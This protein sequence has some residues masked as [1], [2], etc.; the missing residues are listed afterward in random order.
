MSYPQNKTHN[1]RL[2]H[3]VIHIIHRA[4][5]T[6]QSF[7]DKPYRQF[8]PS[9]FFLQ[10]A[11]HG[12]KRS[13]NLL[14]FCRIRIII[15]FGLELKKYVTMRKNVDY[16][17]FMMETGLDK[18]AIKELYQVFL[19]EI[20]GEKEKLMNAFAEKDYVK[21]GKIVHN[22]K[23]I[24]GSFKAGQVF[25]HASLMDL[26]IK[27]SKPEEIEDGMLNLTGLIDHAAADIGR[28]FEI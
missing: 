15:S 10:S 12:K 25:E 23:G 6:K 7:C 26:A 19:D 28:F 20:L 22:I 13:R 17:L 21:L 14:G 5:S 11:K 4:L 16:E 24:S 3:M 18:E 27:H 1:I 8:S 9:Y 2:I